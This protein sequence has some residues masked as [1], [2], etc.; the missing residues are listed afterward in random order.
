MKEFDITII[1]KYLKD[2]VVVD[3]LSTLIV[4]T[5]NSPVE[6]IFP[7]K[8]LFAVYSHTLW[9]ANIVNYL[10][11]GKLPHHVSQRETRKIIQ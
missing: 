8:H 7:N 4:N 2:N 1:D 10:V 9:Y 3:L 5:E 6:D 11:V